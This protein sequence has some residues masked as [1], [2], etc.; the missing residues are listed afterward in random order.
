MTIGN[1]SGK[2]GH[3]SGKRCGPE[4]YIWRNNKNDK[5]VPLVE[6]TEDELKRHYEFC[7]SMLDNPDPVHTGRRK[8]KSMVSSE[9][10][11]CNAEMFI[12]FLGVKYKMS[13][14]NIYETFSAFVDKNQERCKD[15]SKLPVGKMMGGC[16]KDFSGVTIHEAI[17]ACLD[18]LGTISMKGITKTFICSIGINMSKEEWLSIKAEPEEIMKIMLSDEWK[19]HVKKDGKG[20]GVVGRNMVLKYR[21]NISPG[22]N[23]FFTPTGLTW[24]QFIAM[25]HIPGKC[26]YSELSNLQL[27]TLRDKV[28][29]LLEIKITK[30]IERWKN[31][32]KKIEEVALLKGY[33]I[34]T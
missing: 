23:I 18:S 33:R 7:M 2:R 6:C 27:S 30:Q 29:P 25:Y 15:I 24:Q 13:R 4:G 19:E 1:S 34:T 20:R 31:M 9:R 16:P 26:K 14:Y 12:R 3:R 17:L 21:N 10:R 28:L 5:G 11:C 8:L 22:Y 32:K